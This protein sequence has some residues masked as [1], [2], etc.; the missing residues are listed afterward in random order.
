METTLGIDLA[1]QP[2]NT[3]LCVMAW[4]PDRAEIVAL[5]RGAWGD[6]TLTD[7]VLV[8]AARGRRPRASDAKGPTKVAIDAPFGW[9][10][11]FVRAI[12]AHGGM[13]PWPTGPG[14]DRKPFERRETDR[15]VHRRAKK[16]PLSVSTDRIAYPAMRCAAV[17]GALQEPLGRKAVAR[18]GTGLV[19]EAYPDAALR[20]WLPDLWVAREGSYKGAS[21]AARDRRTVLADTLIAHLGD[22]AV[23]PDQ[24]RLCVAWDDC[25]DALVCALLARAVQRGATIAPESDE[26]RRLARVEGWIHLPRAPLADLPLL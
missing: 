5:A 11:P 21:G 10:E 1:S 22:I 25:L 26:Q 9:P 8:A 15:F 17:L 24:R 7:E 3:A 4:S 19:A 16:L 2:R 20:L 14:E 12:A 18:D 6:E 13:E 23:S